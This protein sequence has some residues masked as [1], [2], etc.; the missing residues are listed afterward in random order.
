MVNFSKHKNQLFQVELFKMFDNTDIRTSNE[1][2]AILSVLRSLHYYGIILN[3]NYMIIIT[4]LSS[5]LSILT[6]GYIDNNI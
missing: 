6:E 4:L 5:T 2:F 3:D 1:T